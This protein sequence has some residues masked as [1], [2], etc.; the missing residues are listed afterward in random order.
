MLES[1]DEIRHG[2]T[3]KEEGKALIAKYDGEFPVTYENEFFEY[4]KMSKD[5]FITLCDKFRP[6]HIWKK[7]SN[8]WVLKKPYNLNLYKRIISRLDIKNGILV[9][10]ISLEGVRNLGNPDFFQKN[11]MTI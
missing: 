6:A 11:I 1:A 5:E 10:G 4:I 2:H 7:D 9:K 8:R 3:T